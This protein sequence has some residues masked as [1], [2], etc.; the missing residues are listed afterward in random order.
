M[1][2]RE[3]HDVELES[4]NHIYAQIDFALSEPP[5]DQTFGGFV[6]D[7]LVGLARI[8]HHAD[9]REIG[10]FW[11]H[12]EHRGRSVATRLLC[13]VLD[14]LPMDRRCFCIPFAHLAD[15]YRA[16][17]FR[18]LE[19][20]DSLPRSALAKLDFCARQHDAGRYPPTVFLILEIRHG[21]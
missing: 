14:L 18:D 12:P 9:A 17:G 6:N 1:R 2:L 21:A 15:F 19:P 11:T 13:H 8:N 4:A 10:G 3:L 7:Q 16:H 20:E 5:R